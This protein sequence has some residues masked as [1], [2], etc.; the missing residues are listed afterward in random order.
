MCRLVC[1]GEVV[2]FAIGLQLVCVI[3][4]TGGHVTSS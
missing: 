4:L 1:G 3:A 2:C